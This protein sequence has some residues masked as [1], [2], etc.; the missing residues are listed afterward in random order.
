[1]RN[2][3]NS[4]L[5]SQIISTCIYFF[6]I[7]IVWVLAEYEWEVFTA[8]SVEDFLAGEALLE[9]HGRE[10]RVPGVLLQRVL[11]PVR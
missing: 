3:V 9:E 11:L 10:D 8:A 5:T 1:M 6:Y 7:V 2:S 4:K